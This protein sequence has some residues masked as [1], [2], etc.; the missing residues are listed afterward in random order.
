MKELCIIVGVIALCIGVAMLTGIEKN[1]SQAVP[2]VI[3]VAIGTI[4][5]CYANKCASAARTIESK[6]AA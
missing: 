3:F 1:P 5:L 6:K 2:S 4:C